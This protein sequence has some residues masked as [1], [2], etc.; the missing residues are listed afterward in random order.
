MIDGQENTNPE[1]FTKSQ[2]EKCHD[3]ST[4]AA[5][6]VDTL[7]LLKSALEEGMA[8]LDG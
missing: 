4:R 6:K 8:E 3:E 2:L 7:A 1:L 5:G